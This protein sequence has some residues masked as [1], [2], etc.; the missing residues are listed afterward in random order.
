MQ[1][2]FSLLV[3]AITFGLSLTSNGGLGEASLSAPIRGATNPPPPSTSTSGRAS[4][5]ARPPLTLVFHRQPEPR[6]RAFSVLAPDGWKVEGGMFSVDPTQAG[7]SGNSIDTKCDLAVKR[8]QAG[9]VMVRWLPS[10]NYADFSGSFEFAN[11]AMLF[12]AGR[13]YNGMLVRPLLTVE[14]F[15]LELLGA[16]HPQAT[17]IKVTQRL[18]LPEL[19]D[20]CQYLARGANQQIASIGKP[21]MTFTA[22]ALVVEYTE[23]GTAYREALATA[24]TDWRGS[25]ALWNNQFSFLMRAPRAEAEQ[26]KPI[27]DIIRQSIQFNP[28][29]VTRY[30]AASGERGAV[31]AETLRYLARIDQEIYERHSKTRSDIQHENYLLLTGQEEYVNPFT[32]QVERD[33][34]DYKYRWTTSSG[35]R[36]YTELETL[37]PN[38]DPELN[39]LEWKRTPV[40]PR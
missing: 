14:R 32:K 21:P 35:D 28:E 12:P 13:V 9:S 1:R 29:W 5:I 6:Q 27:L 24:L 34:S 11:M 31:A 17:D 8:D 3:A 10:Y 18:D 22:G 19:V 4:A 2:S 39:R 23:G 7:G 15:L 16:L 36:Y 26:W 40:R 33:G 20:I 30:V 38:R 37:D 25:A